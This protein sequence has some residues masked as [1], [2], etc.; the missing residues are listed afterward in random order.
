MENKTNEWE[1]MLDEIDNIVSISPS[2]R[3]DIMSLINQKFEVARLTDRD[4]LLEMVESKKTDERKVATFGE[5]EAR[6]YEDKML[7]NAVLADIKQAIIK[8]YE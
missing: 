4:N 8:Y 1:K 2:A 7:V 3:A 6:T 5:W